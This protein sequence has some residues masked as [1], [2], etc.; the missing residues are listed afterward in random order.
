MAAEARPI[1]IAFLQNFEGEVAIGLD[2]FS[3]GQVLGVAPSL[4]LTRAVCIAAMLGHY[5]IHKK[6]V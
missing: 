3:G 2:L 4:G 6:K 5:K 1:F